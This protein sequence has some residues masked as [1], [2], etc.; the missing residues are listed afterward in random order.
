MTTT[1]TLVHRASSGPIEWW[2]DGLVYEIAS[3]ELGAADLAGAHRMLDHVVSLGFTALLLRPSLLETSTNQID[4]FQALAE[5]AHERGLRVVVRVSGAL[6][7]VTGAHVHDDDRFVVGAER[8]GEGILERAE[9]FLAAGADG[10]DL[11]TI[12]PPEVDERTDLGRLTEYFTIL[13]GLVAM[14]VEDGI[15]GADVSA[16]YPDTMRHHLQEDWLHHL[17]DDALTLTRWDVESLTRHITASLAEHDRFGA[18]PVWR[19]LPSFR[20]SAAT[21]PGDGRRWF[22]VAGEERRRRGLSMQALMLAL[23]GA[24]Y[25]RQGDEIA[26][27]DQDKPEAAME[28]AAL[29][30][31]HA[32]TQASQFGS[33]LATVRHATRLRRERKLATS[34]LAFVTGLDWCP[35]QALT[36]LVRDVVVLVNTTD[37]AVA[38]PE[39][40]SVLLSSQQLDQ[41]DGLLQVPPT[42]TA[43]L[44]AATVR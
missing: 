6:G 20:L 43:W 30:G 37:Q 2:R 14:H 28:L 4:S 18:P 19:Y 21:D 44:D 31:A 12:I 17:R 25:L 1:T 34:T 38:L 27:L 32:H 24:L 26:L 15:L 42:T 36:L 8:S 33:P 39:H 13:H 5:Q 35:P 7:P 10:V 16:D 29:V 9:A 22:D 11:G 40:A 23:P 3:P 41:K